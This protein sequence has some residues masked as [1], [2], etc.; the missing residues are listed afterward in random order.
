M[1]PNNDMLDPGLVQCRVQLH[2]LAQMLMR[3]GKSV[4]HQA[5]RAQIGEHLR[6]TQVARGRQNSSKACSACP[7]SMQNCSR[8]FMNWLR[9][10]GS[11]AFSGKPSI[12]C[13]IF[14]PRN[15]S[16]AP[17]SRLL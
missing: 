11:S 7:T 16:H 2:R 12:L 1:L 15:D 17:R 8:V 9:V 6:C 4:R 10:W 5:R 14:A 13:E 3:S